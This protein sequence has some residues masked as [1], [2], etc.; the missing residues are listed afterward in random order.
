MKFH[1]YRSYKIVTIFKC[2][3]NGWNCLMYLPQSCYYK[4]VLY[5][6]VC[7]EETAHKGI[8]LL[9]CYRRFPKRRSSWKC[10]DRTNH[11]FPDLWTKWSEQCRHS[12]SSQDKACQLQ[13]RSRWRRS[14]DCC[15]Q[16]L[17]FAHFLDRTCLPCKWDASSWAVRKRLTYRS[18]RW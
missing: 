7:K 4:V 13:S 12:P 9:C 15:S 10:L 5:S 17:F 3:L 18:R 8:L 2:Y 6:L 14:T 16:S 11:W 1:S